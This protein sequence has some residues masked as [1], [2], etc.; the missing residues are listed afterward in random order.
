MM[1]LQRGRGAARGEARGLGLHLTG[2]RDSSRA[3][4]SVYVAGL[5][6]QGA[7]GADG[8]LRVGDEIL[9][10]R[11]G[12]GGLEMGSSGGDEEGKRWGGDRRRKELKKV[13][14]EGWSGDNTKQTFCTS[15]FVHG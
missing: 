3:R 7:A 15:L 1:E 10:V 13:E 14:G 8:R 4:M 5:D 6:P 11:R 2:N 12:E 9:E